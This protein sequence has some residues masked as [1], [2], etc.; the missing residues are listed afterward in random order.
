MIMLQYLRLTIAVLVRLQ[1]R[2]LSPVAARRRPSGF[3]LVELL[4][5][6]AIIGVLVALLLPAV[7]AA[8]EAARRA[9]CVNT[10]K[11]W[12]LAMHNY[13]D[14]NKRIPYGNHR[15]N[16]QRHS[17]PP[18]LWP[19]IEQ[20]SLY[21]KYNWNQPFHHL[22]TP[23]TGNEALCEV[24]VDQYF[25]ASDKRGFWDFPD[26]YRRSRG[27]YVLNWGN[28]PYIPAAT[29]ENYTK[30]APF[31][32]DKQY[33]FKDVRDGLSKTMFLSESIQAIQDN[34][35]DFRGDI[36]NDD[37]ACAQ[38]MTVNSPN[39]GVDRGICVDLTNP[40][41][42]LN[43]YGASSYVSARSRH[44]GGVNVLMGDGSVTFFPDEIDITVWRALGTMA[45]DEQ[46]E[47]KF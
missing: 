39:A 19:F 32:R 7:Q 23:H 42:C 28:G 33:R 40:A 13:H 9:Q 30:L 25:C 43:G 6:I 21:E 11:Q 4:V 8:R 27:N 47:I 12:G 34:H 22:G 46:V 15:P 29:D 38:Y 16:G 2:S 36:L 18:A 5:V 20:M 14:A 31:R 37:I 1:R 10:V 26:A 44:P 35:F 45:G 17:W 41:E 24:Q 3:T